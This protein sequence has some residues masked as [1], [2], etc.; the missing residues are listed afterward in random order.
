M[1]RN[2]SLIFQ[3]AKNQIFTFLKYWQKLKMKESKT[4]KEYSTVFKI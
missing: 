3:K 1:E 4:Y 2:Y